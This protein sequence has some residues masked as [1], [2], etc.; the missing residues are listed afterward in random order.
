MSPS[1]LIDKNCQESS[2]NSF[3]KGIDLSQEEREEQS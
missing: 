3:K 2:S 1:F